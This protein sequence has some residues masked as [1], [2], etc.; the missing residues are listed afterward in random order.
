MRYT[1]RVKEKTSTLIPGVELLPDDIVVIEQTG[2]EERATMHRAAAPFPGAML[3][4]VES[5]IIEEVDI[6]PSSD[7]EYRPVRASCPRRETRVLPLRRLP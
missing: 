3:N 7:G 4:H 2:D 1:F 5:G 6:S